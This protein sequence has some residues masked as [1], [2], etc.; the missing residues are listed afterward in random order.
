LSLSIGLTA[1]TVF[2][3]IVVPIVYQWL[4]LTRAGTLALLRGGRLQ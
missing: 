1:A 4:G 3:L 2:T